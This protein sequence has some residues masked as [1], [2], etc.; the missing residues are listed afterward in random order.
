M[1]RPPEP[2]FRFLFIDPH[3]KEIA[4]PGTL[5]KPVP[6]ARQRGDGGGPDCPT[7]LDYFNAVRHGIQRNAEE[8]ARACSDAGGG[9][10]PAIDRIDIICEKHGSDYHPARIR[11]QTGSSSCSFVMNVALSDRGISRLHGEFQLLRRLN[12]EFRCK[13]L[14]RVYFAVEPSEVIAGG[15][16][17]MSMFLGEWFE[18]FHEFHLT[19]DPENLA[20]PVIVWDDR[21]GPWQL[22]LHQQSELYRQTALILSYYYDTG[23]FCEVY[24]WHHAAGD[25]VLGPVGDALEV[26]LIT[27]RQYTPR[28]IFHPRTEQKPTPPVSSE[29]SAPAG[30]CEFPNNGP[31]RCHGSDIP[32]GCRVGA[33]S[34]EPPSLERPAGGPPP[35]DRLQAL[36]LFLANLTLRNRLDRFDGVGDPAMA[37]Q[38]VIEPTIAGF[39][40]AL[41]MHVA[42]DRLDPGLLGAFIEQARAVSPGELAGTFHDVVSSYPKEA[43]ELPLIHERLVD[44]IFQVYRSLKQL[45]GI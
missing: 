9:V 1:N 44:H 21:R 31:D 19:N 37:D 7:Y 3:G 15:A 2:K 11:V 42:E 32:G 43:P 30:C 5:R 22:S 4:R 13:F 41:Q 8:I 29:G 26:R 12:R 40:Q 38:L 17:P 18:D 45:Q 10:G 36:W 20:H 27:A 39:A 6:L 14:P 28:V 16:R 23:T 24:P 35:H 33:I 25:F 34:H